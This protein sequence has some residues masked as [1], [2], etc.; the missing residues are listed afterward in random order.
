MPNSWYNISACGDD[1]FLQSICADKKPYFFIYVY[2]EVKKKYKD[3]VKENEEKCVNVHG[4]TLEELRNKPDLTEEER[5]FLF[6]YDYKMPIGV[7]NCA[8]NRICNYVEQQMNGYKSLLRKNS[9]FDYTVLKA[10]RKCYKEHITALKELQYE[11][12]Q[13]V[14]DY[15]NQNSAEKDARS[16]LYLAESTRKR[17]K[18]LCPDDSER[19]N[20]ILDLSYKEKGNKQF[21]WDVIGELIVKRLEEMGI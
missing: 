21:C 14:K 15:K 2:D 4:C 19:L 9:T 5:D 11:Y 18:E 13:L 8:M 16:R 1:R 17:A 12:C 10:D 3:Y 20:I 6:W 7:G